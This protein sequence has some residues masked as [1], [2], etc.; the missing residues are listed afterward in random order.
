MDTRRHFL[1]GAF[2]LAA[3]SLFSRVGFSAEETQQSRFD[4][5]WFDISLAQWSINKA[6]WSGEKDKM[7][8]AQIAKSEFGINAVEYVNQF[9]MEGYSKS[10]LDELVRVS[11]GEGVRNV[12][13]MCDREGR[14]GDPDDA[15]REQAVQNHVRWIEAA[16][17]LGCHAIR[18]NAASEGLFHEQL[19]L[20][21]DGLRRL[22]EIGDRYGINVIVEN[23]GGL[24]SNGAW[25][26]AV[27][28]LVD[29]P[30]CGTLPDFGNFVVNRE[31]GEEYD[32]YLGTRQLM[33]FAKGVSAKTYNFNP[34]GFERDMDYPQLLDIVKASGYRGYIGIEWEGKSLDEP[35]GILMTKK[36]LQKLGG[37][38]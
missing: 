6:F 11:A 2:G 34:E 12:L 24:S 1:K 17:A 38:A 5:T 37:R 9:Y 18:V 20:A 14:L 4:G 21:A 36:L 10:V 30:R 25:L 23:H 16:R 15:K 7:R 31:T 3:A 22:S 26:A 32:K 35:T 29:H 19:K 33:P 13:I 28:R 27:M 8:F